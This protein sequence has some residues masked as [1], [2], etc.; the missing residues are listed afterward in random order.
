MDKLYKK[1]I[2][3]NNVKKENKALSMD[4]LLI[5]IAE[6]DMEAF[7]N[8]YELTDKAVYGFALSILKNHHDA[9]DVMQ[10][11]YLRIR[12][13]AHLYRPNGKPM[14]W[15]FTIVRNIVFMKLRSSKRFDFS[16]Y[17]EIEND[18]KF[19]SIMDNEDRLV[20]EAA[21]KVLGEDER[22]IVM[23]HA[24]TGLRHR[25]IAD[26]VEMPLATVLSKYN[27]ALKKMKKFLNEKE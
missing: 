8:L 18:V 10:D 4:E 26:I 13:A 23:L 22:K 15:I 17:N 24:I 20:L 7:R 9:E 14:A 11:T 1:I 12:A 21:F 25:E 27:R 6:G 19:S 5:R 16:D 3:K 2:Y